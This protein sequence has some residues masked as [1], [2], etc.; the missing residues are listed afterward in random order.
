MQEL[1]KPLPHDDLM[2]RA[3]VGAILAGHRHTVEVLGI[4][5]PDDFFDDRHRVIV[6]VVLRLWEAGT[7]P[8]LLSVHDE[9]A[10]SGKA[11]DAGGIAYVASLLESVALQ[12]DI[13]YV[14]RGLRRMASSRE[15]VRHADNIKRLA[16]GQSG[17]IEALLDSAV[18][19]LSTLARDLEST[20]DD[21]TP[22]FDSASEAIATA[23]EG[24]RLKIYTD[25]D[26]LD[27]WTGGFREGEL[28]V[29]TAE[30]GTGKSLFAAQIRSRACRDGYLALFC[31][32]EM[33]RTHLASRE[34]ATASA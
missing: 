32:G 6:R 28:V 12:G 25:V 16:L 5:K 22:Y 15:V 26:T 29:L 10:R 31:S 8:D 30:T 9:L 17:S 33:S 3:L 11:E 24:A 4:L 23:R 18:E 21:G 27:Q 34:L 20:D 13:L 2:E 14:L 19:K 1:E 7:R